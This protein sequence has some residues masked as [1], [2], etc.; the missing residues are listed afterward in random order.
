MTASRSARRRLTLTV[1]FCVYVAAVTLAGLEIVCRMGWIPNPR[2][3]LARLCQ[4]PGAG[5]RVLILGDSFTFDFEGSYGRL[6]DEHLRGTGAYV[7][8]LAQPGAGPL[9]YLERLRTCGPGLAPNI[10]IVNYYVGNDTSDTMVAL[11][12]RSALRDG[13]RTVLNASYVG[14]LALELRFRWHEARRVRT[15][16][17]QQGRVLADGREVLSPFLVEA[18]R[19]YPGE[20]VDNLLV[21]EPGLRQAFDVNRG[22]LREMVRLTDASGGRLLLAVLPATTQVSRGHARFY[23]DLGFRMDERAFTADTPQ[24]LLREFCEEERLSCVDLLGAFRSRQPRQFYLDNDDHWNPDGQ[25][26]A[27]SVVREKLESLGWMP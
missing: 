20:I 1:V 16:R 13:G 21:E 8:N 2:Y 5:R 9:D 22:L 7:V 26:L 4:A 24:R 14:A 18:G 27:Y 19:A 17:D 3:R 6:L 12:R 11:Q 25:E 15:L 10:V 23:A